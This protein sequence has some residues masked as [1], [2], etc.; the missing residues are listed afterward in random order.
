LFKRALQQ[1]QKHLLP[2]DLSESRIRRRRIVATGVE[3][4][5][6]PS[7]GARFTL[8][9]ETPKPKFH[10]ANR[11]PDACA[12]QRVYFHKSTLRRFTM[13]RLA[14]VAAAVLVAA[15]STKEAPKTDTAAPAM[16][17]APAATD[18]AAMKMDSAAMKMDTAAA[19]MDSA[20]KKP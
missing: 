15:C 20:A 10:A 5:D 7:L 11:A 3:T 17:P 4:V 8:D 14:L 6:P 12:D 19:K 16:A 9:S 2:S 13:K 18:T 1:N